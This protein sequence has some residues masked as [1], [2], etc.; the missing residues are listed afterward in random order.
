MAD[1]YQYKCPNCGGNILYSP[2][3]GFE[4]E[5]CGSVFEKSVLDEYMEH[6][7]AAAGGQEGEEGAP[8]AKPDSENYDW[9]SGVSGGQ[10][11]AGKLYKCQSCGAEIVGE[12]TTVSSA[13]PYCGSPVVMKEM[14]TG[15]NKP[16]FIIP[17]KIDKTQAGEALKTLYKGKHFIPKAFRLTNKIKEIQ[18][19]YVPFWLF[20]CDAKASCT[21]DATRVATWEDKNYRYTK[22]DHF[23]ALRDGNMSFSKVPVDGSFKMDDAYMDSIEPF[24]YSGLLDFDPAYLSGYAANKYDMDAKACFPRAQERIKG[25]IQRELAST[26]IGYTGV[27]PVSTQIDASNGTYHYALMPV[28]MVTT[29]YAGELYTF[30]VNGQTGKVTGK[31]PCDNGKFWATFA[32]IAAAVI[33]VAQLFIF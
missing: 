11:D 12:S 13:C 16:D 23:T 4:C 21:F 31:I 18:P 6:L 32:G 8:Q 19:V 29:K 17:F 26:V 9:S 3:A 15:I 14:A 1:L 7:N 28:Y 2:S 24:D 5:S 22:T 20:D 10:V 25:S 27:T 30:A 33:A